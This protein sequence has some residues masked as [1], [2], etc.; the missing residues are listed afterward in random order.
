MKINCDYCGAQIDTDKYGTCPNCGGSYGADPELL[1]AQAKKDRLDDL[2]VEKKRLENER[3]RIENEN[4]RKQG[5]G[6][7][8]LKAVKYGCGVPLVLLGIIFI[9]II[10]IVM[11][12]EETGTG[13][14][15]AATEQPAPRI[16]GS[17]T[18]SLDPISIP[19]IPDIPKIPDIT[20]DPD[21]PDITTLPDINLNTTAAE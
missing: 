11:F 2:D 8:K 16:T 12:E 13:A 1:K 21:I 15:A 5:G 9:I 19:D 7:D 6:S 17:F 10:V 4:L 3:L 20:V 14:K 18:I